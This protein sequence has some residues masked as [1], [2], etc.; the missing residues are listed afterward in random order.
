[1]LKR[2]FKNRL[3]TIMRHNGYTSSMITV[4]ECEKK[5]KWTPC[6][7]IL[8]EWLNNGGGSSKGFLGITR[9][10]CRKCFLYICDNKQELIDLDMISKDA[11]NNAGFPLWYSWHFEI[12][13]RDY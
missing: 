3:T 7:L 2:W 10:E 1:M 12:K 11:T 9:S 8:R 13:G 5:N 4:E 6:D